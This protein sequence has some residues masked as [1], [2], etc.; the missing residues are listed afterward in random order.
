[1]IGLGSEF[2]ILIGLTMLNAV[3]A[4]SE[5]AVISVRPSRMRELADEGRAAARAVLALRQ[6]PEQ[7]LATVQVGITV[8]GAAAGA[9]GGSV[10]KDPIAG[11]LRDL[12]AGDW[13]DSVAFATVVSLIS[14]LSI[15]F[16]ELV[17]KSIAL[18]AS[19]RYALLVAPALLT[20]SR[21]A[22]PVVALLTAASNL[23]LRPLHD[24]TTFT[25]ARMSPDELRQMVE[26]VS[27]TGALDAR[28][29]EIATRA[30]EL[31]ELRAIAVMVPRNT[32]DWMP[33]DA[34][35]AQVR[36]ILREHAHS[37]YPVARDGENDV[38][39][40]VL[41][42]DLYEQLL[43]RRLDLGAAL[44]KLPFFPERMSAVEV[45]RLLQNA[46]SKI[47]LV[48]DDYGAVAGLVS[49]EDIAEELV[50]EVLTE[51]DR[52]ESNVHTESE[53]TFVVRGT[54]PVHQLN[55]ELD[56]DLPT[57]PGW[58]TVAGLVISVAGK[59]PER[60]ER[61]ALPDGIVA[62]ILDATVR[63]VRTLRLHR[64]R[65]PAPE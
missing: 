44:R 35:Q 38:L 28:A 62:E 20:L 15:V 51:Y 30:I 40:Y 54:T 31:G 22:K 46:R 19:E 42:R 7:F 45:L 57:G 48:V 33:A 11:A 2:A 29:G 34:D 23:V 41:A 50:G 60:S 14:F 18:R 47:G 58:S 6:Q 59:I 8:V 32:I 9:F 56:L 13:A 52:P 12:G 53:D 61:I 64:P 21:V 39:G 1:M 10:M 55:R 5:I 26:D 25:E 36:R 3:F 43:E 27:N 37:R 4:G 17:P 16:G 24:R 65:P 63:G 49:I